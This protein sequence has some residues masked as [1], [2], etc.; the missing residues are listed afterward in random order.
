MLNTDK[1]FR[2][3]DGPLRAVMAAPIAARRD[4]T[5]GPGAAARVPRGWDRLRRTTGSRAGD[6]MG[7]VKRELPRGNGSCA[8]AD[9]DECPAPA[10]VGFEKMGIIEDC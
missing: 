8:D 9:F 6:A 2:Q 3:Q 10:A 5:S 4:H 7:L 1:A